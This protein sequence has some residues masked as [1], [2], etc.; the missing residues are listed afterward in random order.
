MDERGITQAELAA[1]TGGTPAH[2]N[3]VISGKKDI[4]TKFAMLLEYALG[5]PMN[6]WINL[7]VHYDAE[8]RGDFK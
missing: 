1:R 7:Q 3:M 4:S 5:V 2:L 8:N 6:F